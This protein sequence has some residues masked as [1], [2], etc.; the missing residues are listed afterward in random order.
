M[1][2]DLYRNFFVLYIFIKILIKLLPQL[3][4]SSFYVS[5]KQIESY[6]DDKS[7]NV[8]IGDF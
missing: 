2:L 6:D 8:A 3:I 1:F 4:S 5:S 7:S